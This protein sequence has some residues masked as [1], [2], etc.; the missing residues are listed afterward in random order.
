VSGTPVT[1]Y[2][3][4]VSVR[5][6]IAEQTFAV[7]RSIDESTLA[8]GAADIPTEVWVDGSGQVKKE[9]QQLTLTKTRPS[10][11]EV[12]TSVYT[13]SRKPFPVIPLPADDATPVANERQAYTD[14]VLHPVPGT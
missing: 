12:I 10:E 7:G 3:V 8:D 11:R 4:N 1:E 2:R 5:A 6:A 14:A 13:Y 9:Q